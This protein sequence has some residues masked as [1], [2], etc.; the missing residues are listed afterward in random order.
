MEKLKN[1]Y[2]SVF[3]RKDEHMKRISI[4]RVLRRMRFHFTYII[5][6]M[7]LKAIND[8]AEFWQVTKLVAAESRPKKG[9]M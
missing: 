7:V 3:E 5:S 1:R 4:K 9:R 2:I 8:G 6:P